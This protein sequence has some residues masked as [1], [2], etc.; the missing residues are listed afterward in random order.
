MPKSTRK[1]LPVP[2]SPARSTRVPDPLTWAGLL[3]A[4]VFAGGI[5]GWLWAGLVGAIALVFVN[6]ARQQQHQLE[7]TR[8]QQENL[9]HFLHAGATPEDLAL[10]KEGSDIG[11]QGLFDFLAAIKESYGG[12]SVRGSTRLSSDEQTEAVAP[13]VTLTLSHDLGMWY[14]K[15]VF[16]GDTGRRFMQGEYTQWKGRGRTPQ[17]AIEAVLKR[18]GASRQQKM[19]QDY[20]ARMVR[21]KE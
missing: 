9:S 10:L 5:G 20:A 18:C 16:A 11:D 17:E 21:E 13:G 7:Y 14:A 6:V 4:I 2:V 15:L 8:I 12:E 1:N 3:A 19:I